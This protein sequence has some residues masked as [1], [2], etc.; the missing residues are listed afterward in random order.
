MTALGMRIALSRLRKAR[1]ITVAPVT[2]PFSPPTQ[3]AQILSGYADT[4]TRDLQHQKF[5]GWA[6]GNIKLQDPPPLYF[7][8]QSREV[9]IIDSLSYDD[10]GA[11]LI[12]ATVNDPLA[13]R[14]NAFSVGCTVVQYEL[15][16]TDTPDF[17][18]LIKHAALNE[19]SL[20]DTPAN[21]AA[22]VTSRR[23]VSAQAEFYGHAVS[24]VDR[25]AQIVALLTVTGHGFHSQKGIQNGSAQSR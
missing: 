12:T 19:I 9:G 18:A 10:H 13:R 23:D 20:T 14:A 7:K 4:T 16:N 11:L 24:A 17:F 5:L 3:Y 22:I 21:P 15:V 2:I 8:H 1:G 25:I 6:F